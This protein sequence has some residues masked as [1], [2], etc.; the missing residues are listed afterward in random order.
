MDGDLLSPKRKRTGR[1]CSLKKSSTNHLTKNFQKNDSKTSVDVDAASPTKGID[2][3]IVSVYSIH[4][5]SLL[6]DDSPSKAQRCSGPTSDNNRISNKKNKSLSVPALNAIN[7]RKESNAH[8]SLQKG[9]QAIYFFPESSK[10]TPPR[11]P[12]SLTESRIDTTVDSSDT[13]KKCDDT[14][15]QSPDSPHS[16]SFFRE[17]ASERKTD[18]GTE[19]FD[20]VRHLEGSIFGISEEHSIRVSQ[21]SPRMPF[22][23]GG[24]YFGSSSSSSSSSA[25]SA[26]KLGTA[27]KHPTFTCPGSANLRHNQQVDDEWRSSFEAED[28]ESDEEEKSSNC[29]HAV[30]DKL[31]FSKRPLFPQNSSKSYLFQDDDEHQL[32]D[33][34]MSSM[35]LHVGKDN[36]KGRMKSRTIFDFDPV[37]SSDGNP[38]FLFRGGSKGSDYISDDSIS[39]VDALTTDRTDDGEGRQ[40]TSSSTSTIDMRTPFQLDKERE[41]V[42]SNI[43]NFERNLTAGTDDWRSSPVRATAR[44]RGGFNLFSS[45]FIPSGNLHTPAR[46]AG[47]AAASMG[48]L[49]TPVTEAGS[50]AD[51]DMGASYEPYVEG[52]EEESGIYAYPTPQHSQHENLFLKG[53]SSRSPHTPQA[54][55]FDADDKDVD[56]LRLPCKV[57]TDVPDKLYKISSRDGTVRLRNTEKSDII[58]GENHKSSSVD[59][60]CSELEGIL[61]PGSFDS[62]PV[63]VAPANVSMLSPRFRPDQLAFERGT[64]SLG[65]IGSVDC[66]ST[67]MRPV[68]N[69]PAT[70]LRTPSWAERAAT[71]ISDEEMDGEHHVTRQSSLTANRVL[72]SLSDTLDSDDVSFHRDFEQEGFLG[73]GTFADVYR[74]REK[75]GKSY[76]VKKS[77]RQFRSKKDRSILMGEVMIMKKLGA[78]PCQYIVQLVRAWQEDGYFFVQIDLAERG[79]LKDLLTDLALKNTQPEDATIWHIL[80]DVTAGLRHIHNCGV[81][82]LGDATSI[83]LHTSELNSILSPFLFLQSYF[84]NTSTICYCTL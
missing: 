70:P 64:G 22:R 84:V 56:Q 49:G 71:N 8:G 62:P 66:P 11:S 5:D 42:G 36:W 12:P 46:S 79:T 6:L 44:D 73:S 72:L 58:R 3:P 38:K 78:A 77:K 59:K 50:P 76:A 32:M 28:G 15:V 63:D 14:T 54:T 35:A 68:L 17:A 53:L 1:A 33:N 26:N 23:K 65:G 27:S 48:D 81:V 39:F 34:N 52:E 69:C 18:N 10:S 74:A 75:D 41:R 60:S 2:S 21:Y 51:I 43:K 37:T 47:T 30:T 9:E 20:S 57:P 31:K 16:S 25:S 82:H 4:E 19:E 80:H 29:S 24:N 45:S 67:P 7:L 55:R 40:Q 83:S 61:R 13:A